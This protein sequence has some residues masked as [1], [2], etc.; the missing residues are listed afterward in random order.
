MTDEERPTQVEIKKVRRWECRYRG[1]NFIIMNLHG[2]NEPIQIKC[3]HC[4]S[5]WKV[6][7]SD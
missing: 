1:H 5:C 2:E 7:P 6:I 4:E 3:S